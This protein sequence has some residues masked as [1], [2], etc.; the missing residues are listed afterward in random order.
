MIELMPVSC[1]VIETPI[2]MRII[3]IRP[4]SRRHGPR[5]SFGSGTV[6]LVRAGVRVPDDASVVGLDDRSVARLPFVELTTV[7]TDPAALAE[8][9]V[10]VMLRRLDA[11]GA[12]PAGHRQSPVLMPRRSVTPPRA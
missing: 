9:A 4:M 2:A 12:D 7:R 3:E 5:P 10:E 1:C 8:R 11:P 6:I